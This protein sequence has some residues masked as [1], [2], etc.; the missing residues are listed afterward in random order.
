MVSSSSISPRTFSLDCLHASYTNTHT[1]FLFLL[2]HPLIA[3]SQ[4][5]PF[6]GSMTFQGLIPYYYDYLHKGTA[7]ELNRCVY[8]QMADNPKDKR[9]VND[10]PQGTCR[11]NEEECEDCRN[12][13][14]EDVVSVHFTL[15]Q[16]PWLCLPQDEDVI[17]QRLCHKFHHEWF[18]IRDDLEKGWGRSDA[19]GTYHK[20]HFFGHCKAHGKHG[21]VPIAQPYGSSL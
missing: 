8:N 16:K 5:G 9:T 11:T 7:V 17:Q 18:R 19:S 3:S 14:L 20:D 15:C 4:V 21:Y 13:Q 6:Y 10:I 1:I 2:H 12:R